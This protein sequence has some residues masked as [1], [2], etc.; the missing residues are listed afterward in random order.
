[1]SCL[2]PLGTQTAEMA[3]T[4]YGFVEVIDV[5]RHI[6]KG[7]GTVAVDRLLEPFLLEA[8]EE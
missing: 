4:P 5:L 8:A 1:M 3:V 6:S 2:E 7:C